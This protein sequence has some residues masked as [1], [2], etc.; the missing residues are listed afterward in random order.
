MV[1]SYQDITHT[2]SFYT[3]NYNNLW[4]F[5]FIYE[6]LTSIKF[7]FEVHRLYEK[8]LIQSNL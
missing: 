2:L 8:G 6:E 1:R 4:L 5:A 3:L 7:N